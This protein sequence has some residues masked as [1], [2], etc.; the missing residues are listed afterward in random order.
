MRLNLPMDWL[1]GFCFDG[2]SKMSG[3]FAGARAKLKAQCPTALYVH[4]SNHALDLILQE[5]AREV[6][7]VADTLSFV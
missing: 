7:L 2:A 1:Q 5:V 6:R 4:C 3:R